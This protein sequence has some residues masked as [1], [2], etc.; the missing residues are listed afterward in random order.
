MKARRSEGPKER[1]Q[2]DQ[3]ACANRKHRPNV[4]SPRWGTTSLCANPNRPDGAAISSGEES[5]T[6]ANHVDPGNKLAMQETMERAI[7]PCGLSPARFQSPDA[8]N[9]T[10]GGVGAL[11]GANPGRATRSQRNRRCAPRIPACV[12]ECGGVPPLLD[13]R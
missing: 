3:E 9:R 10:S 7:G 6:P 5:G 11:P 4:S 2:S 12:L 13:R 8:E 1:L